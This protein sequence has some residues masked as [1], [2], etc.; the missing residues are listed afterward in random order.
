MN[1]DVPVPS[2]EI[3]EELEAL[4]PVTAA[5]TDAKLRDD[6]LR[7][8]AAE[9]LARL[10]L[11]TI[12]LEPFEEPDYEAPDIDMWESVAQPV[13]SALIAL[14][15]LRKLMSEL[16]PETHEEPEGEVDIAF[17]TVD[18]AAAAPALRD[19]VAQQVDDW[20]QSTL[21]SMSREVTARSPEEQWKEVQQSLQPL[22]GILVQETQ[23]FGTR[24]RNPSVIVNRWVLLGDL[25]EFK[26]KFQKLLGAFR[27]GLLHPFTSLS[28]K[29]LL[30]DYRTEEENSL[31]LRREFFRLERDVLSLIA[32]H[33]RGNAD[34]QRF[35]LEE[36][37]VRLMRFARNDAFSVVRAPDKR[38]LIE[39]RKTLALELGKKTTTE[40]RMT[41]IFEDLSK[42]LDMMHALNRR[43]VLIE[44]DKDAVGELRSRV[45]TIEEVMSL[46]VESALKL[47]AEARSEARALIGRDPMLD[48]WL[49]GDFQPESRDDL[50]AA[51][52]WVQQ[53]LTRI[54]LG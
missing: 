46:D 9:I 13:R 48:A 54:R 37:L 34:E 52:K 25:Q 39:F 28:N 29:E 24:I 40:R 33:Q 49:E 14:L 22:A 20:V 7:L 31:L 5:I 6:V 44:H 4:A 17:D 35:A 41:E 30:G 21:G 18:E 38:A 12:A 1:G 43:E 42:F 16:M 50:G 26:G 10:S 27:L 36:L 51:V 8:L 32:V 2:S 47:Y 23:R 19:N 11:R 53:A 3:H 15:E 45:L